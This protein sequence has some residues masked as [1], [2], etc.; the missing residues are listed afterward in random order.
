MQTGDWAILATGNIFIAA[1]SQKKSSQRTLTYFVRG[2]ITVMLI[3]CLTGLDSVV[4]L[5]K[6]YQQIDL[7]GQIQTSQTGGQ[8]YSD[9]SPYKVSVLCI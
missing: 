9:T 6:N 7:L 8:P 2:S 4:L 3:S 1:N 5:F